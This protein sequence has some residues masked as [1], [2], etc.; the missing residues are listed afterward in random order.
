MDIAT[1]YKFSRFLN[2]FDNPLRL[3]ICTFIIHYYLRRLSS[4]LYETI[5]I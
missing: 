1:K 5:L 3:D 2:V 4:H